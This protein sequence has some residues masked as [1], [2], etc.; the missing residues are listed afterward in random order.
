VN[1]NSAGRAELMALP[2]IGAEY[3]DRILALRRERGSFARPDDLLLVRGIGPRTMERLRP[4]ITVGAPPARR[5]SLT[6]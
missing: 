3:A 1:I 4:L 6:P 5:D 2:G